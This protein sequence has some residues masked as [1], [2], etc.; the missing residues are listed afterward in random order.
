MGRRL[1]QAAAADHRVLEL[2]VDVDLGVPTYRLGGVV[3]GVLDRVASTV[4]GVRA[5]TTGGAQGVGLCVVL[6]DRLCA[7]LLI[8]K[9]DGLAARGRARGTA[10]AASRTRGQIMS[11]AVLVVRV[12]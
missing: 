11:A 8:V 6:R 1:G 12:F 9:I 4:I 3:A 2:G 7:G 5:E 10:I